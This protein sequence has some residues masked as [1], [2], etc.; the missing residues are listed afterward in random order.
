MDGT[1]SFSQHAQGTCS[2]HGGVAQRL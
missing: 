2:G 1:Y